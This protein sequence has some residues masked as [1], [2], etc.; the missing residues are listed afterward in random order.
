MSRI[1]EALKRAEEELKS[2]GPT[3]TAPDLELLDREFNAENTMLPPA[4]V[5][6]LDPEVEMAPTKLSDSEWL[7]NLPRS[8]WNTDPKKLLFSDANLHNEPG[9]EEF[10]T[11]R[12]RLYQ[13]R[14]KR[15]LKYIMVSSALPGEGKT[16]ISSNL[17][18]ALARQ[19]GRRV[20][21]I[22]ADVRK[23]HMHEC[24]GTTGI[25]GLTDYLAGNHDERDIVQRG[26]VDNLF[27]IAGGK[28]KSNPAELVANGKL[29]KLLATLGPF[30]DWVLLDS[31]PVVPIS[32]GSVIARNVDGVMLVVKSET[33]SVDLVQRAKVELKNLPLLGVVL[34]RGERHSGYSSYYYSYGKPVKSKKRG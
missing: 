19:H 28:V 13:I 16:F 29:K 5:E 23:P 31:P 1:H 27:F 6:V 10:R 8:P 20:L 12:S 33:T 4:Q 21:L 18:Y 3:A 9:M 22:D 7:A 24:F 14:E 32:D 2:G 26:A 34:N 30:F 25:P 11:L 17:A 15:A